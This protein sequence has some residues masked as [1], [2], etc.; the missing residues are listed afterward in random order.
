ME[1]NSFNIL[2]SKFCFGIEDC[3]SPEKDDVGNLE[4][5]TCIAGPSP[6]VMVQQPQKFETA[7]VATSTNSLVFD[8]K[9]LIEI[10]PG[11]W[12]VRSCYKVLGFEVGTHMSFCRLLNGKILI[13]D[14]CAIDADIKKEIDILTQDGS[15]IDGVIACHP[16]H[17]TFFEPFHALYP[18]ANYYGTN[19]HLKRISS[20]PWAGTVHNDL[21]RHKN[22]EPSVY[23]DIPDGTEFEQPNEHNHFSSMFVFHP[24]SRTLHVDDTLIYRP[25]RVVEIWPCCCWKFHRPESLKFH[26]EFR[27]VGLKSDVTAP[28]EFKKWCKGICKKWDFD[29]ICAAHMANKIGGAKAMLKKLLDDNEA[30]F[31]R[32]RE[33]RESINDI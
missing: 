31:E 15:L 8:F 2:L 27:S 32:M 3:N 33:E 6:N 19:R 17:T 1:P 20:I 23:M 4:T 11:F 24:E 29:N 7:D 21:I 18:R 9:Y 30:V 10:G 22:W 13:I 25:P 14:V 28:D 16:F 26:V 5:E 12:N